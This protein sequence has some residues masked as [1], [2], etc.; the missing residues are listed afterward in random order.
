M[1]N[2]IYRTYARLGVDLQGNVDNTFLMTR[3]QF[4]RFILD[5]RLHEYGVTPMEYDRMIGK[6]IILRDQ[7][8]LHLIRSFLI[9]RL[10][11]DR[12][13]AWTR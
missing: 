3:M 9:S 6:G 10:F 2:Q 12:K 1:L 11:T 13:Y 4:W 7:I 8:D 5:C